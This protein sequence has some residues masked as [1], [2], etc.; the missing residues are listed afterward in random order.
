M[1]PTR[2]ERI[3]QITTIGQAAA[4][5]AQRIR[6]GEPVRLPLEFGG[7]VDAFLAAADRLVRIAEDETITLESSR[8]W[9]AE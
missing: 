1:T 9:G 6:G 4:H 8:D 3:R 2:R 5:A 7:A